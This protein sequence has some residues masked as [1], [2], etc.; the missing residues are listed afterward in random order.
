MNQLF[1]RF[2]VATL[3]LAATVASSA[4]VAQ[5]SATQAWQKRQY[6][7]AG[8]P[9]TAGQYLWSAMTWSLI[10]KD[11]GLK[12]TVLESSGAEESMQLIQKGK[13]D[14][15]QY[16]AIV[17]K[18]AYGDKSELRQMFLF[19]PAVWQFPVAI[20]SG[21]KSLRDLDGKK[22]NPGPAGGGSTQVTMDIMDLLGIKPQY[23]HA[24]L[25]D[26]EEAYADRQIVGFSF[27][28]T[29]GEPTSAMV[30]GNSSRPMRFL[31]LT[32]DEIAK[33]TAKWP[34]LTKFQ[35]RANLYVGQTEPFNTVAALAVNSIAASKNVP[36][37]A[38]Y[39]MTKSYWKNFDTI[40]KQ[41]PGV[42]GASPA[43]T[44]EGS[45]IPLHVGALRYYQELGLKIPDRLIPPEAKK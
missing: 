24:T 2:V 32:D 12:I 4:A 26:A 33:I 41:F 13:A 23:H 27:R 29:G 34:D 5:G 22:W 15:G 19:Q 39:E 25:A 45:L 20:D 35:V 9:A 17:L 31:S 43:R 36:A 37:D 8:F 10:T 18:K 11:T 40:C 3:I 42:C 21:I 30:E 6:F 14:M 28:G 44:V 1:R 7:F 16:D 38:V